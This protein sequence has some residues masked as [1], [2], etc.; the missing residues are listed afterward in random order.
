MRTPQSYIEERLERLRPSSSLARLTDLS[1]LTEHVTKTALSKKYRKYAVDDQLLPHLHNAI[2]LNF[3]RGEPLKF[4]LPFG[5]Y[6]LW[7]LEEAPEVDWAELFSLMYYAAWLKP[8]AEA[9][10]PGVWFDFSSDDVILERIDNIP[11]ADTAAYAK[12]FNEVIKFLEQYLPENFKFT[13]TPVG[14]RY[15]EDEF[16][17]E[18]EEKVQA[19]MT[20]NNGVLPELT[21]DDIAT[22]D[23]NANPTKEQL[24]DP[25]WRQKNKVVHDAYMGMSK[26]RP[27]TRAEDKVVVFTK[28]LPKGIAVGTTK[29]SIAKFWAG[30]GAL[31][32]REDS[33]I[34]TVL[35][36]EQLRSTSAEWVPMSLLGLSG[37]NFKRVRVIGTP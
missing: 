25:Q 7:S 8:V 13:L 26:R 2:K 19:Y 29:T 32:Q 3:E 11:K 18:L 23:L 15:T 30:V 34:E 1:R 37:K 33:Y 20:Q 10:E 17:K 31:R 5:G 12:S 4:V 28:Q 21:E 6:K 22:I 9:Y 24:A 36:P 35:S 27:Y 16:N 14:S